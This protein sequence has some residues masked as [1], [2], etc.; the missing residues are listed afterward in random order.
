MCM[1]VD[2]VKVNDDGMSSLLIEGWWTRASRQRT[3]GY[4][5]LTIRLRFWITQAGVYSWRVHE[6]DVIGTP[7]SRQKP[8]LYGQKRSCRGPLSEQA[9]CGWVIGN[10]WIT[11]RGSQDYN[12]SW[13][14]NLF[15]DVRQTRPREG[16]LE[17]ERV[18][19]WRS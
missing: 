9:A 14:G 10:A 7:R 13:N 1:C 16:R 19:E 4:M 5:N 11:R 15:P 8:Y 12:E 17:G 6:G 18:G 2:G 3:D